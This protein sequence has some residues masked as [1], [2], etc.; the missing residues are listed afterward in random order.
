[1]ERYL[2][3]S[4]HS[5]ENCE[6]VIKETHSLGYLHHFEWGCADDVHTGWA[7][8]EAEDKTQALMSVPSIVRDQARAIRVVK[9]GK[10][11]S[12]DSHST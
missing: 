10:Q 9:Y 2:I 11:M 8:L 7:F 1:M 3:E 6:L 4:N 5:P 12:G